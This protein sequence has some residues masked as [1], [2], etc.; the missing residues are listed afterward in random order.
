MRENPGAKLK[1]GIDNFHDAISALQRAGRSGKI[2]NNTWVVEVHD[3]G[4]TQRGVGIKLH[5]TVIV[6]YFPEWITLNSGGYETVTTKAR[7][8]EVLPPWVRVMQERGEWFVRVTLGSHQ[9]K[10]PFMDGMKIPVDPETYLPNPMRRPTR[11]H[12]GSFQSVSPREAQAIWARAMSEKQES[13]RAKYLR[14]VARKPEGPITRAD[15]LRAIRAPLAESP[16]QALEY[17]ALEDRYRERPLAIWEN[18]SA[19]SEGDDIHGY[20]DQ[21]GRLT[22]WHGKLSRWVVDRTVATY[23]NQDGDKSSA[24]ILRCASKY[25]LA[26][27]LLVDGGNLFRGE[28]VRPE[29]AER[30]AKALSEYWD[31]QDN[32]D[33][34]T[35][36][37]DLPE[38]QLFP[39]D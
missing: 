7:M 1:F 6:S 19:R 10:H 28:L 27:Y 34:D 9:G 12:M 15:Y 31:D 39:T 26:G 16:A 23:H 38:G 5:Q 30:R 35:S 18:P 3:L 21:Q 2:G 8:N 11:G 4:G 37:E 14:E 33:R 29:L 17:R 25:V 24:V 32:E 36:W 22:D 13:P 20:V